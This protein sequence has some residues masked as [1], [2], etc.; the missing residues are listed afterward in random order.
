METVKIQNT[1]FVRDMATKAVLNTDIDG[2]RRYK[3]ARKRA[4]ADRQATKDTKNRL[5]TIEREMDA[6][7]RIVSELS[8]LRSVRS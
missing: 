4:I 8:V 5:E 2:L 3:E 6:L 1:E 7:K